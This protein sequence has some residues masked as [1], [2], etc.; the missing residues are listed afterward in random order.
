MVGGSVGEM[1]PQPAPTHRARPR[2]RDADER[3]A[4]RGAPGARDSA[5]RSTSRSSRRAPSSRRSN[6][7]R[8]PA[9]GSASPGCRQFPRPRRGP[10][11]SSPTSFSMRCRCANTFTATGAG[12]SAWSRSTRRA[13]SRSGSPATT[14]PISSRRRGGR[15]SRGQPG[16]PSLD[17]RARGADGEAGRR[18]AVRRLRPRHN[19]RRRHAAGAAQPPL[20]FTAL[21]P[22]RSRHNRPCRFRRYG[23]QRRA[24]GAA[25][26]GPI[27]QGDF[28][29]AL[30]IDART[31]ALSERGAAERAPKNSRRRAAASSASP[32]AKWARCSRRWRSRAAWRRLRRG[33][34]PRR[35]H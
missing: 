27:D 28:L 13:S 33:S 29:A 3:R 20:R 19:R 21:Q 10:P 8:S 6:T 26:Y 31:H 30:G 23:A 14:S 2:P 35:R 16:Q 11:S 17:V 5:M 18:R 15:H 22:R 4:A 24:A 7:K 32:R 25:V 9:A 34:K 1:G 12:A